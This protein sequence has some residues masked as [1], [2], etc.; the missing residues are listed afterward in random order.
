MRNVIAAFDGVAMR[1]VAET[2]CRFPDLVRPRLSRAVNHGLLR[3]A[4]AAGLLATSNR[5]PR[6]AAWRSLAVLPAASATAADPVLP[7]RACCLGD[8][9]RNRG[10]AEEPRHAAPVIVVGLAV[11]ASRV[12]TGVPYPSD[13]LAGFAIDAALGR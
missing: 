12:V 6:R 7:V 11:G 1:R 9:V 4:V 10:G 3:I 13:V 5:W 8:C 2:D